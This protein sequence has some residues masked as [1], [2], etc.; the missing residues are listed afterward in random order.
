M[1]GASSSR[2]PNIVR[3]RSR[4]RYALGSHIIFSLHSTLN[5]MESSKTVQIPSTSS[6]ETIKGQCRCG[7]I[8]YEFPKA[9][10]I[11]PNNRDLSESYNTIIITPEKQK[12]PERG[13]RSNKW[14]VRHCHCAACRQTTGALVASW[15]D[16][17][18]KHLKVTRKEKAGVYR[19]SNRASR[20]FCLICGASLFYHEDDDTNGMDISFA[21]ITTPD[22]S[23]YIEPVAHIWVEDAADIILDEHG[24][25]GGLASICNDGL[26]RRKQDTESEVY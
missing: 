16:I 6:N 25:G 14:G 2:R 12:F 24:K 15:V 17:P 7:C 26:P 13:R 1:S 11:D 21:T 10:D 22:I 3:H 19:A 9:S 8:T 20:E 18:L 23:D 5:M 4:R